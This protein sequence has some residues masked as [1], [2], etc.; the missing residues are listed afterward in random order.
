[1]WHTWFDVKH[2]NHLT[3][4]TDLVTEHKAH[5]QIALMRFSV[6]NLCVPHSKLQMALK[7]LEF[8]HMDYFFDTFWC[9]TACCGSLFTCKCMQKNRV[10]IMPNR[11]MFLL[12]LTGLENVHF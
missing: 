8:S 10:S 5:I 2:A 6:N 4:L 9:L 11:R 7:G 3:V 1:M 12:S